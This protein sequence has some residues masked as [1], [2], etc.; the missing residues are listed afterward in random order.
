MCLL[1]TEEVREI[2]VCLPQTP[3]SFSFL[4]LEFQFLAEHITAQLKDF[5]FQPCLQRSGQAP[6]LSLKR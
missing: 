4:V 5:I 3:A 1:Q 2:A 6:N